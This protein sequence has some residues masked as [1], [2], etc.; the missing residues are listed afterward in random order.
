MSYQTM[1]IA[2]AVLIGLAVF[3]VIYSFTQRR[4]SS[5]APSTPESQTGLLKTLNFL[6]SEL[7]AMLPEIAGAPK[8]DRALEKLMIQSG[9]PWGLTVQEFKF[10]R[11]VTGIVGLL[12]GL[13][14]WFA[15][16]VFGIII[17]WW[18]FVVV[19]AL[20]GFFA[21]LITYRET[22]ASRDLEFKKQLPDALDLIGIALTARASLNDALRSTVVHLKP[23]VL[24]TELESVIR[25]IDSGRSMRDALEG[26]AQRAPSDG[27]LTFIRALQEANDLEVSM[28]GTLRSRADESREELF[29]LIKTRAAALPTKMTAVL[30]PT[31]T[32]TL[33]I[34]ILAPFTAA[35]TTIL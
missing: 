16:F 9:N 18:P 31:L 8:R 2:A 12:G 35:L 3:L 21:P 5:Y 10:I 25:A 6:G 14:A 17:P 27:I 20:L 7:H 24:K 30:T 1:A 22:A 13:F 32:F 28:I 26:F 29:S 11:W 33:L 34:I 19:G 23:S 15:L 4:S